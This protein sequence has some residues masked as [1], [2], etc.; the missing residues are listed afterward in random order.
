MH[1][2]GGLIKYKGD[3]IKAHSSKGWY[4]MDKFG[5]TKEEEKMNLHQYN[6]ALFKNMMFFLDIVWEINM[7]TGTAVVLENRDEPES[8]SKEYLYQDLY[9][10][11]LANRIR[12]NEYSRFKDY[13]AFERLEGL[14]EEVSFN[15]RIRSKDGEWNLHH[16]VLTPA[17]EEDGTLYCVYLCARNLQMEESRELAEYHSH[18]QFREALAL[19]SYFHYSFDVTGDGMIHEDFVASDGSH[20]IQETTGMAL[21]IPF[22]TFA[23][24][25][26]ESYETRFN[27]ERNENVFTIDYLKRA[28]ARNERLIDFEVK[29]K[30]AQDIHMPDMMHGYV[31]LTEYP[32]DK[33]IHA[34]I[35]W[36]GI[37]SYHKEAIADNEALKR[38]ISQEEQFR[39]ASLSG[40]LLV[41]NIN[42]TRNLIENEFYEI[43]DGKQYPMLQLVGL[44]APCNFD[45]FCKRW[46]EEKVS[47]DSRETFLNTYNRQYM[48]DAYDRGE[49]QIE[50]EFDTVIGR[51]IRVTL[52]NTALLVEDRA[53]GD[54]LAMVN[55]KD[56][57]EQRAKEY[58]QREAL[59]AAYE[60]A[61]K[62]S[63]AKSEFLT[64]MSHDIRTP[65][66]AII[67]M[68]AIAATHLDDIDRVED[69]L[70]KI[71][72]S[73]KHLL[74][75]IN[76]VLDMS[77]IESGKVHLQEGDF[78][79]TEMLN[80]MIKIC[81]SQAKEKNQTFTVTL[82]GI[83]HDHV[84]GDSQRIQQAFMNVIDNAM[85][86]TPEG[87]K[88]KLMVVEKPTHK[89]KVGCYEFI[90][91]DNGMGISKDF[92]EHLFEPF[93]R[94]D[95]ARV[96]ELPGTGLGL[97]ITKNI[98]Q[99]MNGR[100]EVESER[101][102]GAKFRITIFLK[103][104]EKD[105]E[106]MGTPSDEDPKA[107]IE[108]L[109]A[110]DFS[111]YRGL[112]VEDNELNAE[113][114]EEIFMMAGLTIDKARDGKEAV[115][116]MAAAEEDY[117]DVIFM[118]IQ[119]P[120]MNGYE[121]TRAIRAL[122]RSDV[123]R[124][125]ILAMSANAFAED[126]QESKA[127]GM[128]EHLVKPLD[129]SQLAKALHKWLKT[130]RS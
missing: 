110:E 17:F 9:R 84:I 95:D 94:A 8:G 55:S 91:E 56:V 70:K 79:F 16:I 15:V 128:N 51:G 100:I 109:A 67:G 106:L 42:L 69:C 19:N 101:N 86:Y 12:V 129:F 77:K 92:K 34:S 36:R 120:I 97:M 66:N 76:E 117:Y 118:D 93:T 38:T 107:A 75:H 102:K 29:R 111:G 27:K 52:R 122:E 59:R 4:D 45:E 82:H 2:S 90:I 20:P 40:A 83:A 116:I 130:N 26:H 73:S 7:L 108:A 68:T 71:M 53:S 64:R 22:E 44:T 103:L 43:V 123:K 50:I 89:P 105:K 112:L 39:R 96:E 99:M 63:A 48:L 65:M 85:K 58:H 10:D 1:L 88:I 35:I 74:R 72:I 6:H 18:E 114:A 126:I 23:E 5:L 41:Y 113:I 46:C 62:A 98:V 47:E 125:P 24:K 30:K 49:R 61:N 25:W 32:I 31:V 124:M 80:D 37:G 115:D 28:F 13:L 57:S 119:M 87:G 127:S 54:I 104:Q 78:I 3:E 33:H 14:K 60:A 21:P 81:Q 11:Y 121:A